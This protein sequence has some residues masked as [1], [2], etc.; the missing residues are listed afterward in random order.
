MGGNIWIDENGQIHR[1]HSNQNSVRSS[2]NDS[3]SDTGSWTWWFWLLVLPG[4][5]GLGWGML[6]SGDT[7][8]LGL[9]L[10]GVPIIIYAVGIYHFFK[11][12]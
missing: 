10:V 3:P 2:N 1:E 11:S 12:L 5:I 7:S 9:L 6:E 4:I 8:L